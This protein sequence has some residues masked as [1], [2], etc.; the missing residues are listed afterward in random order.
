MTAMTGVTIK[1]AMGPRYDEILTPEAL[2]FVVDLQ[3]TF[4]ETR[5]RLLKLRV[6]RQ[7][8]FDAG[9]LPDFLAETKHIRDAA[10]TV[11]PIPRISRTAASRSPAP[12]TARWSSTR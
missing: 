9:A 12:W 3:R 6:E 5:K 1:G 11:A 8:Q 7:K 4:N 10:W 2:A